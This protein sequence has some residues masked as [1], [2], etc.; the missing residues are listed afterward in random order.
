MGSAICLGDKAGRLANICVGRGLPEFVPPNTDEVSYQFNYT[1]SDD[2]CFASGDCAINPSHGFAL[3]PPKANER[4]TAK[5]YTVY[6]CD[7]SPTYLRLLVSGRV[8]VRCSDKNLPPVAAS[9]SAIKICTRGCPIYESLRTS[10]FTHTAQVVTSGVFFSLAL[11]AGTDQ[12]GLFLCPRLALVMESGAEVALVDDRLGPVQPQSFYVDFAILDDGGRNVQID[13]IFRGEPAEAG[14]AKE[15]DGPPIRTLRTCL[16][17]YTA[18]HGHLQSSNISLGTTDLEQVLPET[19]VHLQHLVVSEELIDEERVPLAQPYYSGAKNIENGT[20]GSQP[21]LQ[22]VAAPSMKLLHEGVDA[23][24][25]AVFAALGV[26]FSA[27]SEHPQLAARNKALTPV[28]PNEDG[29]WHH[30][31][32]EDNDAKD[33]RLSGEFWLSKEPVDKKNL[34]LNCSSTLAQALTM[35]IVFRFG[36]PQDY[37][38]LIEQA[39]AEGPSAEKKEA[40]FVLREWHIPANGVVVGIEPDPRHR[41]LLR[42]FIEHRNEIKDDMVVCERGDM[43]H[44][45]DSIVNQEIYDAGIAIIYRITLLHKDGGRQSAVI[46]W[47]T[48]ELEEANLDILRSGNNFRLVEEPSPRFPISPCPLTQTNL[49]AESRIFIYSAEA[50]QTTVATPRDSSGSPAQVDAPAEDPYANLAHY[51]P[52][53]VSAGPGDS[54][55]HSDLG[56]AEDWQS[57]KG[58]YSEGEMETGPNPGDRL[59][60]TRTGAASFDEPSVE[61]KRPVIQSVVLLS[62]MQD[63]PFN[64]FP[65][66]LSP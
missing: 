27:F 32:Y 16:Q 52:G 45:H 5:W 1:K 50:F 13:L 42:M 60:R 57:A 31:S 44:M 35:C 10:H 58:G 19:T 59:V 20:S 49:S 2:I 65:S 11:V 17:D 37:L 48:D 23:R 22:G 39:A 24:S 4:R 56:T 8:H 14:T 3:D 53:A 33:P 7:R 54:I 34:Y 55:Y 66:S 29:F 36:C 30:I 62:K 12:G 26:G 38:H 63:P 21:N 43:S 46:Q 47:N 6:E 9:G 28:E 18:F 40:S 41:H 25:A 15:F 64:C 51:S 61:W